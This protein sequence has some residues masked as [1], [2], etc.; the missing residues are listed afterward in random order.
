MPITI[1]LKDDDRIA[2]IRLAGNPDASEIE[3]FNRTSI[4]P[5]ITKHAPDMV[6]LVWDVTEF[7]WN[8]QQFLEFL[9]HAKARRASPDAPRN[10][11]QY[12][13]GRNDWVQKFRTWMQKNYDETT[14]LFQSVEDALAY[15]AAK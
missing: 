14:G 6:Y 8:L 15:L 2:I 3:H 11:R 4:L 9:R 13:V 1:E 5:F 10:F 7:E 12:Y